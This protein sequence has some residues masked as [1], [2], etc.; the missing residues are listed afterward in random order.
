M[1]AVPQPLGWNDHGGPDGEA[2]GQGGRPE[3][4]RGHLQ[5][6][7]LSL[8]LNVFCMKS[9]EI[10]PVKEQNFELCKSNVRPNQS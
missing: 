8:H 7:E 9:H 4:P 10:S 6:C 3:N 2:E 5:D 1:R